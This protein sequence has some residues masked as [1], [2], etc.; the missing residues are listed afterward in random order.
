MAEGSAVEG[1]PTLMKGFAG[2]VPRKG[3]SWPCFLALLFLLPGHHNG[4]IFDLLC[5]LCHDG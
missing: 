3:M 4:S 2:S 1:R 5:S